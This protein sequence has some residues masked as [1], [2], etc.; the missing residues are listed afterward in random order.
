MVNF[1][2]YTV[3]SR[4]ILRILAEK[5]RKFFL[6]IHLLLGFFT[7]KLWGPARNVPLLILDDQAEKKV[8]AILVKKICKFSIRYW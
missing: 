3:L 2:P 6:K 4:E 5:K 1:K 8:K 7:V